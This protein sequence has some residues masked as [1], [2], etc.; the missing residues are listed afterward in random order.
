MRI[1]LTISLLATIE[2]TKFS[3]FLV[4]AMPL[5]LNMNLRVVPQ[6]GG[7]EGTVVDDNG[8][9][10]SGAIVYAAKT[11]FL[12]GIIP[13]AL[14]DKL[15]KFTFKTLP[16]GIYNLNAKKDEDGYPDSD[17]AF[18]HGRPPANLPVTVNENQVT[19][20]VIFKIGIKMGFLALHVV[21]ATTKESITSSKVT[22]RRLDNS[23][24]L[25]M[26]GPYD[27]D[28][29]IKKIPVPSSPFTVEISAPG[30]EI[31]RYRKE[32]SL[33]AG[34]LPSGCPWRNKGT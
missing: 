22:L 12:K 28:G 9:S 15:G 21:N 10:I 34:R 18:H 29:A 23:E 8:Q 3:P 14:T 33:K 11:G 19:Q 6:F 1:L 13:H 5:N 30:Y 27:G 16:P 24:F 2:V 32:G 4:L 20:N 26:T 31:W 17:S 7:I 25:Y